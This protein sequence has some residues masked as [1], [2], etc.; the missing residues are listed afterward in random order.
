MFKNWRELKFFL[1]S[2]YFRTVM[3]Y[4]EIK[5]ILLIYFL[6]FNNESLALFLKNILFV[7]LTARESMKERERTQGA[8]EGEGEAGSSLSREPNVALNPR[9]LGSRPEPK[10][11]A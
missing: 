5:D 9:T 7:Y 1:Y 10:V 6:T 8:A 4:S 2:Y 11:D 3:F